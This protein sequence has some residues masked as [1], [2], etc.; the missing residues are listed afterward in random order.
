MRTLTLAKSFESSSFFFST[1]EIRISKP[2]IRM[3]SSSKSVILD[4][5]ECA[6]Y[7]LIDKDDI[8]QLYNIA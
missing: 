1:I 3:D 4:D 5:K 2:K 7:Y 8:V 6:S